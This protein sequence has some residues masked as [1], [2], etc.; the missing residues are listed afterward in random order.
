M[1]TLF[2]THHYLSSPGGGTFA[3]RAYINAFAELS[4]EM[5]LL[6]PVKE[7][8]GL[9]EGINTCIKLVPVRYELPKVIKLVRI[10]TGKVHRYFSTAPAYIQSGQFDTIV[11]DTSI[12]S[13]RLITMAKQCGLR[14][15][16]IHH[17]FQYEYF[18]DNTHGPMKWI[19]LFW[20]Q[21]YEKQA[22]QL[23]DINLTL[24][25]T[26]KESLIKIGGQQTKNSFAVLGTFEYQ[27]TEKKKPQKGN[28]IKNFVITGDLS[29]VQTYES[30]I[31]WINNLY[32]ELKAVFPDSHL[33]IAGRNP[34]SQLLA[35]CQK[36]N[37]SIIASPPSMEPILEAADCYI[38]PTSLGSGIKL[39]VLDGLKWGLPVVA[40]NVSARGYEQ[41]EETGCLLRYSDGPSFRAALTLLRE[42]SIDKEKVL[43]A[44]R[45]IFS[46]E[47]GCKRLE[48]ILRMP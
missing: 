21:R 23:A 47:A 46:L 44:Y 33:T 38:C 10:L 40:H 13:Y 12:V 15:I 29:G 36:H 42:K 48:S 30:L 16:V 45:K 17:N 39:R 18:R 3:S 34:N 41:M 20:C 19:T 24:T 1:R 22:V 35:L 37:I 11:F 2:I 31:P 5:T 27:Y 7:G 28:G 14:T 25:E 6:Y 26:D 43:T 8:E 32:A 4:D 9:F